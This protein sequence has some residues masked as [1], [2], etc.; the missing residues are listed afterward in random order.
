M[1]PVEIG[2]VNNRRHR[3]GPNV[4]RISCQSAENMEG[5]TSLTEMAQVTVICRSSGHLGSG[6]VLSIVNHHSNNHR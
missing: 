1:N 2:I 5:H 4:S 3:G 6:V